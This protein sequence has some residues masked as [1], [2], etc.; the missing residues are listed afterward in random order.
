[1][2]RGSSEGLTI[3][4]LERILSTRRAQIRKLT[5]KRTLLQ[6]RIDGLDRQIVQLGGDGSTGQQSATGRPRNA[7]SLVEAIEGVL[8]SGKPMGV[9]TIAEQVR[10]RGYR[11]TSSNFRGIVNQT[12]IKE[13]AF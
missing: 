12:L 7:E 1:M 3:A 2:A 4:Q 11:S 6:R 8:K 13:R 9:G 5:H 10:K